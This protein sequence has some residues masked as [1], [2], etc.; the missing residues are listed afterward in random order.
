MFLWVQWAKRAY[1]NDHIFIVNYPWTYMEVHERIWTYMDAHEPSLEFSGMFIYLHIPSCT[2]M[3]VH[4]RTWMYM[5]LYIH[6]YIYVHERSWTL[7]SVHNVYGCTWMHVDSSR[8]VHEQFMNVH[9]ANM[10]LH[11]YLNVVWLERL[12]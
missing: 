2:S 3:N 7:M 12:R 10:K 9:R 5:Y 4:G 11:I 8:A 1:M 6:K